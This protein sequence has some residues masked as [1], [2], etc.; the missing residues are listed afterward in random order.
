MP[1]SASQGRYCS[2][3]G[4]TAFPRVI[5][6]RD[7]C[8]HC[9]KVMPVIKPS[10]EETV[11]KH[12][13]SKPFKLYDKRGNF[14]CAFHDEKQARERISTLAFNGVMAKLVSNDLL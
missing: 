7:Y 1:S 12:A 2:E 3:C 11:V 13:T 5:G 6:G 8:W 10:K 4:W 9:S 14:L